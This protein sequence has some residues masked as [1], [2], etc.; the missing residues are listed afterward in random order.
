MRCAV[1]S[2]Y[3]DGGE[4]AVELAEAVVEASEEGADFRMLYADSASLEE[5]V[6]AGRDPDL[7][8]RRG[9]L[10]GP[11]RPAAPPVRA[12][13]LRRLP[14]LHREDPAEPLL[15]PPAQGGPD[16]LDAAHPRGQGGRRSR[17]RLPA[18]RRDAD[19]ARAARRAG[20][21]ADRHR[22]RGQHRRAL[23]GIADRDAESASGRLAQRG[24]LDPRASLWAAGEFARAIGY[25]VSDWSAT[26]PPAAGVGFAPPAPGTGSRHRQSGPASRRRHPGW[27]SRPLRPPPS[28]FPTAPAA[29]FQP[30]TGGFPPPSAGAGIPA[31]AATAGLRRRAPA[32]L[33]APRLGT[34]SRP[35]RPRRAATGLGPASGPSAQARRRAAGPDR[36]RRRHRARR[37]LPRARRRR[38]A[39]PLQQGHRRRPPRWPAARA[40]N[41]LQAGQCVA[42]TPSPSPSATATASATPSATATPVASPTSSL[43]SLASVLPSYITGNTDDVCQTEGSDD[44]RRHRRERP[45][46]LRP[47]QQLQ[48][49]RGLRPLRG[50]LHLGTRPP[51]TS[52]RC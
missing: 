50:L 30:A 5:K 17:L 11:G 19:H 25:P 29:G 47:E 26:P 3:A 48:R 14:G 42:P 24:V 51:P 2:N 6:A 46:A 36:R 41:S 32:R 12:G 8:G 44:L 49:R 43:T 18:E 31:P 28:G 37:R 40:A 21:R 38:Q 52:T 16:R 20:G 9:H 4:G 34:A 1:S 27:A 39:P 23:P 45:G 7:R 22:R 13:R 33:P 15:R 35:G 10:R